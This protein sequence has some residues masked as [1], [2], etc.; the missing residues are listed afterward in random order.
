M[1]PLWLVMDRTVKAFAIRHYVLLAAKYAD[2]DDNTCFPSRGALA[3]DLGVARSTIDVALAQ[4]KAAWAITVEQR[5]NASGDLTSSIY[6]LIFDDPSTAATSRKRRR[7]GRPE[8]R[9][10]LPRKTGQR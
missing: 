10:T 5:R 1:A 8:N 9:S 7:G 3:D 6:T 4:L 2:R